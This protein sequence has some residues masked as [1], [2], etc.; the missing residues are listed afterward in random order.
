MP[1]PK[2]FIFRRNLNIDTAKE[3][4][5]ILENVLDDADYFEIIN[6]ED[7]HLSLVHQGMLINRKIPRKFNPGYP[8]FE[9]NRST[10][11]K[12][13]KDSFPWATA[14]VGYL[15]TEMLKYTMAIKTDTPEWLKKERT[16]ILR[17][18]GIAKKD[19][20]FDVNS[21]RPHISVANFVGA[22]RDLKYVEE[23]ELEL[24]KHFKDIG[25]MVLDPLKLKSDLDNWDFRP[26]PFDIY[27]D[28]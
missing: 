22:I 17:I 19:L 25:E 14:E 13:Q 24:H 10:F 21:Y 11:L 26:L 15:G 3:V 9:S 6:P 12:G 27:T 20:N 28:F 1:K 16:K 2:D 8:N 7:M 23:V 18:S 4:H 5:Y